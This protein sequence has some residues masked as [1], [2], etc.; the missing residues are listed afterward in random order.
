M[1]AHPAWKRVERRVA[2]YLGTERT[3]LSGRSSRHG[4]SSDSLHRV[5]Y[6]EVKHGKNAEALLRSR[7]R[8]LRLFEETEEKALREDKVPVVVLHPPRW[9]NGGVAHYPAWVRTEV[10]RPSALVGTEGLPA[11]LLR[12]GTVVMVPLL[13]LKIA[14]M[15]DR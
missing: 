6:I 10:M 11:L 14:E 5:L 9:G 13:E 12:L 2:R 4:T 8:L 1:A 15:E 3:P 7:R